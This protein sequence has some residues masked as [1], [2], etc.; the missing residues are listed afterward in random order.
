[1]LR[2]GVGFA[3]DRRT[4]TRQGHAAP[5]VTVAQDGT[6]RIWST[7]TGELFDAVLFHRNHCMSVDWD[8]ATGLIATCGEDAT[9]RLWEQSGR[10]VADVPQPGDLESC[11]FSP[12]GG[13]VA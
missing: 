4:S 12:V 13:L 2:I 11:R 7:E 5:I 3:T 10:L 1:M 9:I 6:G 8:A